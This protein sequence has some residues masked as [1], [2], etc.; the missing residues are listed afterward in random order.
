M[1]MIAQYVP[2]KNLNNPFSVMLKVGI[3][4]IRNDLLWEQLAV[5]V[6]GK[7]STL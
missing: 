2:T 1:K 5:T 6:L 4:S 7:Q 3:L